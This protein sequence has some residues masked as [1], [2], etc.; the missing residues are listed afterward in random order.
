MIEIHNP[1][2]SLG[3]VKSQYEAIIDITSNYLSSTKIA[4][5]KF[6]LALR[7]YSPAVEAFHQVIGN[8]KL[9]LLSYI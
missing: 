4:L 8:F 7:A 6:S 1:N 3:P 9:K 2:F 5:L